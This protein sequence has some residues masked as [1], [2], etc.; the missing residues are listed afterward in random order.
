MNHITVPDKALANCLI[1]IVDMIEHH[2]DGQEC[3]D[4]LMAMVS[5][6]ERNNET[7]KLFF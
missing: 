5:D 3:I 7:T 2:W 4:Y 6:L 1:E